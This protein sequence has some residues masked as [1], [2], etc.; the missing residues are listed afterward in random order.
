MK[1]IVES[2]IKN[3][4]KDIDLRLLIETKVKATKFINEVI[5]VKSKMEQLLS[6]NDYDKINGIIKL[7]KNE[8]KKIIKK[9]LMN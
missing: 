8:I 3:A 9:R 7:M 4:K 2:S 6:K 1:S 5:N